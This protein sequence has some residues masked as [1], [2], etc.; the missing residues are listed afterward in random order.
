MNDVTDIAYR[1]AKPGDPDLD[2]ELAG[3][4]LASVDAHGGGDYDLEVTAGFDTAE[5]T[6]WWIEAGTGEKVSP[7]RVAELTMAFGV[8]L[9]DGHG[10]LAA[11]MLG[12]LEAWARDGAAVT[13]T[14]AP[15]KWTLLLCPGHPAGE[16]MVI[17]RR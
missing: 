12:R 3:L 10:H 4:R 7:D 15:G 5:A 8:K 11:V 14:S 17:P 16:V 2:L 13:M 9:G 1:V 6:G